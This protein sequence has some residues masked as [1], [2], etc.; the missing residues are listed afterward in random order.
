MM[1]ILHT[2]ISIKS[3]FR[4]YRNKG[5]KPIKLQTTFYD[6]GDQCSRNCCIFKN[7]IGRKT[8]VK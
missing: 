3:A 6:C 4:F 7:S 8:T 5:M 1:N 2:L